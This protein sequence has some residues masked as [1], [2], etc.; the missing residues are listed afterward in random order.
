MEYRATDLLVYQL[1]I[2]QYQLLKIILLLVFIPVMAYAQTADALKDHST[3][4]IKSYALLIDQGYTLDQ[5]RTDTILRFVPDDSLRPVEATYYWLKVV[6]ANSAHYD[7]FYNVSVQPSLN[8]TL[9][10]FNQNT[11]RWISQQGGAYAPNMGRRNR[12]LMTFAAQGHAETILY[13]HVDVRYPSTKAIKPVISLE[14]Q[15]TTDRNDQF[16]LI[17]WIAS[18]SVLFLFFLNNLI[19]YFNF[20]HKIVL[21]YLLVQIGGMIYLTDYKQFFQVLFPC[22]VFTI[23]LLPN[24]HLIYYDLGNLLQHLSIMLILFGLVQLTRTYLDTST[25][26]PRLDFMLRYGLY[27]YGVFSFILLVI[28]S[29]L[30]YLESHTLWYHN[31]LALFLI[32]CIIWTCIIGYMRRL[33]AASPFLLATILPLLFILATTLFHVF[34]SFNKAESTLL[35]DLAI[36][37]QALTFS[38]P[39]VA[40]TKLIQQELTTRDAE[41]LQHQFDM[42]EMELSYQLTELENQKINANIRH[43]KTKNELLQQ[44]L[45]TN[46]RELASTTLYLVQKNELLADLKAR[47]VKLT[48][49]H[50]TVSQQ[51]LKGIESI[52]QS[53]QYLDADWGKFKIHFEQVHPDFFDNLLA[54]HPSLTKHEVRLYAYFH[55]NL[56]TKEIAAL[57]NIDPAS[58]RRAKTRL[59]K[60]MA[61][62]EPDIPH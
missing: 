25:T 51:E 53:D 40:R 18:M 12:N 22:P 58:V 35:P 19:I 44:Q 43:E 13:I 27:T 38:I 16:M 23:G 55:I 56:S 3:A 9:Y 31:I 32:A 34:V 41:A 62:S 39:L 42:R 54:K 45:E 5:V 26:L 1:F 20:K 30:V 29:C 59:Y 21:F 15:A 4:Q 48:N 49:R 52:L 14:K 46:Q 57:L 37:T 11:Q 10:Y 36:I 24:G 33:P 28:N 47:L 6:I 17:I 7:E 2:N 60:K 61:V 50:P 8:N